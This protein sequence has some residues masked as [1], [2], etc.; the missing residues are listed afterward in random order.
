MYKTQPAPLCMHKMLND[1]KLASQFSSKW[2]LMAISEECQGSRSPMQ[3]FCST[4]HYGGGVGRSQ[5]CL[6]ASKFKIRST[7][8][9]NGQTLQRQ[10]SLKAI[11][12]QIKGPKVQFILSL[13]SAAG[14]KNSR[15]HLT[16]FS[17]RFQNLCNEAKT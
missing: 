6:E 15:V 3:P 16:T 4:V 5:Q 10:S 17:F 9:Q 8:G 2:D 7:G 14:S 13:Y 12:E 11:P 1:Q